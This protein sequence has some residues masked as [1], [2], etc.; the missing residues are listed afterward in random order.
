MLAVPVSPL[1]ALIRFC[2]VAVVAAPVAIVVVPPAPW[3]ITIDWLLCRVLIAVRGVESAAVNEL[4]PAVKVNEE[5]PALIVVRLS[6]AV[7]VRAVVG[8]SVPA[9]EGASCSLTLGDTPP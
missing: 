7:V 5:P 4:T 2:T 8:A 1:M 6:P 9:A 3:V